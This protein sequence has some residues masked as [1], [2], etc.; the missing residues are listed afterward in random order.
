MAGAASRMVSWGMLALASIVAG[1][2]AETVGIREAVLIGVIVAC[3]APLVAILGPLRG[4]RRLEDLVE[5]PDLRSADKT[6]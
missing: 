6:T 2:L 1:V 3:L 4:I 5:V